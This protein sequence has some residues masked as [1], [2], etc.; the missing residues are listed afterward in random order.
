MELHPKV[1]VEMVVADT[2][3]TGAANGCNMVTVT[4]VR[5][6]DIQPLAVFVAPT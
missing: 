4:G 5:E 2:A 6:V 3:T 1:T